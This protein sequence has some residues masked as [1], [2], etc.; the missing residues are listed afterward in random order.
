MSDLYGACIRS[1]FIA[2][3]VSVSVSVAVS[4]YGECMDL[5][6][7]DYVLVMYQTSFIKFRQIC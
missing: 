2:V 5:F 6:Q 7:L 4:V 3:S 1:C